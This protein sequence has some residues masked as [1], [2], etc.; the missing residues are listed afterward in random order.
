MLQT[1]YGLIKEANKG[2]NNID[3]STKKCGFFIKNCISRYLT[4]IVNKYEYLY[5]IIL[6]PTI[7]IVAMETVNVC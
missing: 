3:P 5:Y 7:V 4:K 6:I 1:G 2:L